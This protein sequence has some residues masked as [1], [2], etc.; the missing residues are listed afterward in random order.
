M[1]RAS[2][3]LA[4]EFSA[5]E[6][7]VMKK[8]VGFLGVL[9]MV[10]SAPLAHAN[11]VIAYQ[12]GAGAISPCV[13]NPDDKNSLG[14]SCTASAGTITITN[15]SGSSN[16]GGDPAFSDQFGS[17]TTLTNTGSSTVTVELWVA[18]QNFAMPV[19]GGSVT[20]ID[21]SSE[22]GI[23][24]AQPGSSGSIQLESSVDQANKDVP[25]PVGT[26]FC[27]TPAATLTNTLPIPSTGSANDTV[28]TVFSPLNKFYS[29]SQM[30]T[31]FLGADSKINLSTSQ[32]LTPVP[33]PMSIALL[34]AVFLLTSRSILRKRKQA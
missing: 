23:T 18:A 29:L 33:E 16:S 17:I 2:A 8:L 31:I 12:I 26:G 32:V 6:M 14:W 13:N 28:T 7:N 27:V 4:S 21:Y 30:V 11:F 5:K 1:R 9:A 22:I 10:A 34:G 19:T 24:S 15:A 20:A 3:R 25:A